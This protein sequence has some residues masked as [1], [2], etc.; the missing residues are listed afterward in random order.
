[1]RQVLHD[2]WSGTT[3][4]A[5]VPAPGV[6]PGHVLIETRATLISAGTERSLVDFGRAGLLGKMRQQPERVQRALEK[7]RTDGVLA[8][9]EAIRARLEQPLA[10]G[11]CNV[12]RV[13]ALGAGVEG[14]RLGQ[15][16]VSNGPH[17]EVVCVPSNL[18]APVPEG[19]SDES[20]C[21]AVLAAVGLHSVRL[22]QP[23]LGETFVVSGL[24]LLGLLVVQLL[25]AHGVRVLGIDP[26]AARCGLAERFGATTLA[27][28]LPPPPPAEG[29][30]LGHADGVDGVIIAA[31][32]PD[33]G[34]LTQAAQL[35]RRRGRIVLAGVVGLELDRALFYDKELSF[36]VAC[37]YG[38][39]R[40]DRRYEEQ[41]QDY[42]LPYVRWTAQRNFAAVLNLMAEGRL[43][44]TSL[45]SHRFDLS[46]SVTAYQLI[47][48]RREPQLG[49]LFSYGAATGPALSPE[50]A[51]PR[52]LP[53]TLALTPGGD[54][55][56]RSSPPGIALIG[57][58]AFAHTVLWPAL[59]H[60]GARL[61]VVAS[62]N[63]AAA[64]QLA[65]RAGA[66]Q[67]TTDLDAVLGDPTVRAVV[68]ATRHDSHAE[69]TCRALRAGKAVYVAKP[70]AIDEDQL[71]AVE[72]AHQQATLAREA[73]P[74]LLV[75]FN[76]RFAPHARR[77]RELL[78]T[79]RRPLTVVLTVN[80]GSV[81][82]EHWVHDRAIGGGRL[83]GEACHFIDL[84]RFL[85][86]QPIARVDAQSLAGQPDSA[87]V[88]LAFADGSSGVL[89]YLSQGHRA[90]P[91]ERAEI[92][93]GGRV[94]RLDNW[95]RLELWGWPVARTR[96]LL[97]QDKGH[98]AE[99]AAFVAA[100]RPGASP[101]VAF[102]ELLEVSRAT[103]R[104]DALARGATL[105]AP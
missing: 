37:S 80:A 58:G 76:R 51:A 85:A 5:E 104:A 34:P 53:R 67:A 39:G 40:Y 25:R 61:Q 100:L 95:R 32:A 8:T 74:L 103:L 97:R 15:R 71:A 21:F 70:L 77:A 47:C 59:R 65:R 98:R 20:A 62:R 28:E 52:L 36:R 63:G 27:A 68:I 72:H 75:G 89:H 69:L 35:C 30:A 92:F 99:A 93:C 43:D 55:S 83:I 16:V 79:L 48:E 4:V 60:A 78:A 19:V 57:A 12:G 96:R 23:T 11:Y 87:V 42:P 54:A 24:G 6:R 44:T 22:A 7:A 9:V 84:L 3:S 2:L 91:K 82:P 18:C 1:M 31:N 88:T 41:G 26:D 56:S 81:P 66:G 94:L 13:V 73:P 86:G 90:F 101:P 45:V 33:K 102:H 38:P 105:G 17:A 50:Q 64:A 46:E 10:L 29:A 14:L 49:V